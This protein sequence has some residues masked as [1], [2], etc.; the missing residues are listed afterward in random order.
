[1]RNLI[2]AILIALPVTAAAG[3][4]H[5]T[6]TLATLLDGVSLASSQTFYI[7]RFENC[8]RNNSCQPT[9]TTDTSK[10]DPLLG[11]TSVRLEFDYTHSSSGTITLTCTEGATRATAT[12]T[13]STATLSG[14]TYTLAWSGVVVTPTL[15]ASRKF[16]IVINLNLAPV[17][18]CVVTHSASAGTLTVKGWLIVD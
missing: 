6:E 3:G 2:L 18:R 10:G 4:Q 14:G 9:S 1:M 16:P 5:R 8:G 7:G 12:G 13:P 15:E 11:Y 17:L